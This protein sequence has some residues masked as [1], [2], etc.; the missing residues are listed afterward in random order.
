MIPFDRSGWD[1]LTSVLHYG[2]EL[3]VHRREIQ[4]YLGSP[5]ALAQ[6]TLIEEIEIQRLLLRILEEPERAPEHM[7]RYACLINM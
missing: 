4:R 6:F 1:D 2:P 5:A 7:R 3:R